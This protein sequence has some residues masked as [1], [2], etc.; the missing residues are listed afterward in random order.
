MEWTVGEPRLSQCL[1]TIC[2]CLLQSAL[3]W[4]GQPLRRRY[5]DKSVDLARGYVK[6]TTTTPSNESG[7]TS[8][9]CDQLR[10]RMPERRRRLINEPICHPCNCAVAGYEAFTWW[11]IE[12]CPIEPR[13][14]SN[15]EI[16]GLH[17]HTFQHV[18]PTEDPLPA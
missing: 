13:K 12:T 2:E 6:C 11:S 9:R 8:K 3:R 4:A 16:P 15:L 14:M 17:V 18:V 7:A 5:S 1:G 10:G